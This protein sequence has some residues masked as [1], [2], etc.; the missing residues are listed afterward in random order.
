MH[1]KFTLVLYSSL[2]Y[3]ALSLFH[4]KIKN[5]NIFLVKD[6]KLSCYGKRGGVQWEG[7]GEAYP[8]SAEKGRLAPIGEKYLVLWGSLSGYNQECYPPTTVS[9]PDRLLDF[10][11]KEVENSRILEFS[12][13]QSPTVLPALHAKSVASRQLVAIV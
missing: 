10:A 6:A 9:L 1:L 2:H 4:H 8:S 7:G 13:I 11:L 12:S 5:M 3:H